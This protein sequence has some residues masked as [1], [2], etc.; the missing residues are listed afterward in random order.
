MSKYNMS[1]MLYAVA[2]GAVVSRRKSI[3]LPLVALIFGVALLVVN[4]MMESPAD[5]GNLRAALLLFGAAFALIGGVLLLLRLLGLSR[6]PYCVKDACFLNKTL[7]KF[8]KEDK[9][10]VVDLVRRGDFEGLRNLPKS[11]VSALIVVEYSSPKS[12]L[13]ACQVFEYIE[14]ELR[15]VSDIKLKIE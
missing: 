12:A 6:A 7:F 3:V 15:P 1:E 4:V 5:N 8:S 11:E 9:N 14:L 13:R 2:D 10:R